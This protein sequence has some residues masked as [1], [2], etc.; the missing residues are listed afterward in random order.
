ML[1]WKFQRNDA[2]DQRHLCVWSQAKWRPWS[3]FQE[4]KQIRAD[5]NTEIPDDLKKL[6]AQQVSKAQQSRNKRGGDVQHGG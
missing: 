1:N 6:D 2:W 4:V 5:K 3:W